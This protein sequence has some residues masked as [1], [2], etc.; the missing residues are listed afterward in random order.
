MTDLATRLERSSHWSEDYASPFPWLPTESPL[1]MPRQPLDEA[2]GHERRA[3]ATSPPG[4][5]GRRFAVFGGALVLTVLVAIGP[6][7]LYGREG[8]DGLEAL[9][10]GIFLVLAAA[11]A[12]WFCTAAAG[13]FVLMT[14]RE[15]DDLDFSPHPL[16]PTPPTTPLMPPY[17]ENADAA[18]SRL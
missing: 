1:S 13:P 5:A 17:K 3:P 9:G 4:I 11:I 14:A 2:P 10:F 15:Q 18:L 6:Y 16:L 12:C 8:F 7:V